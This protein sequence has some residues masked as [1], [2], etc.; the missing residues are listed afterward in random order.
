MANLILTED[1]WQG[2]VR[3]R[4]GVE[5][6][7]LTDADIAQPDIITVAEA[8]IIDQ[9]PGYADLTG[10]KRTWLEAA[11]VCECA[12]LLCPSMPAR[13]PAREQGPHFTREV[14]VD[15]EKKRR[16]L[17]AERDG[18]ILKIA[19]VVTVPHIGLTTT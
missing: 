15:W 18:Y 8:N 17:E 13:L 4:L 7:Y 5:D 6:T 10:S 14:A 2:R 1:G 9:V 3:N 16:D 11:T 19:S 12:A